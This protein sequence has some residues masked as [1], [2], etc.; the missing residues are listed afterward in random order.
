[1]TKAPISMHLTTTFLSTF[2]FTGQVLSGQ[3][4]PT[5]TN[6]YLFVEANGCC[7]LGGQVHVP[8]LT[9]P[10]RLGPCAVTSA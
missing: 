7:I 9:I 6:D 5:A 3:P 4:L 10:M 2:V 1:M 8:L